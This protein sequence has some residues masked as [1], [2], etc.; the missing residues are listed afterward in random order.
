L[1]EVDP[2]LSEIGDGANRPWQVVHVVETEPAMRGDIEQDPLRQ[3]CRAPVANRIERFARCLLDP[4]EIVV[5]LSHAVPQLPVRCARLL[6]RGH[7]TFRPAPQ[8][9]VQTGDVLEGRARQARARAQRRQVERAVKRL[10]LG[11]LDREFQRGAAARRFR[12][13]QLVHSHAE[14]ARDGREQP[15]RGL[16]ASVLHLGQVGR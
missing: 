16:T 7:G 9:L 11:P 1:G 8:L 15:Q 4:R 3:R 5:L 6:R 14:R 12:T 10:P 13:E 2:A